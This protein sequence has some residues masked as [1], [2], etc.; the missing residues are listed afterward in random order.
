MT[1]GLA[2]DLSSRVKLRLTGTDRVRFLNG[3]CTNDVRKANESVAIEACI[4][5]AKGKMNGHV[6]ISAGQDCFLLD[7]DPEQHQTLV[8]RLERYII[9]DDVQI[10]SVTEQLSMIHVLTA[11]KPDVDS[12]ARIVQARRFNDPGWDIWTDSRERYSLLETLLAK[13]SLADPDTAE[14]FRIGQGIPRWGRELTEEIIPIEANLES[15]T[16]DYEKGCYIG[17]EVISRMRMSGQTNKRLRGLISP[18][19]ESLVAG[20]KLTENGREVGWITSATRGKNEFIALGYVKRGVNEVG[21]KLQA[22]APEA[23]QPVVVEIVPLP[24]C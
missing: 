22:I 11:K 8:P 12:A 21:T 15:R 4:L 18:E 24:V 5:N 19:N 16:V 17:Q 3:Q 9:A 20:M 23:T 10:E 6:F 2:F 13:F 7:A 14:S 1:G